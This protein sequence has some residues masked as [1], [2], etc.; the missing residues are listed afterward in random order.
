MDLI[1]K[2]TSA[3]HGS[4][5]PPGSKSHTIRALMLATLA[6]GTSTISDAL[7]SQD[8]EACIKT[9]EALGASIAV[10]KKTANSVQLAVVGAST[11]LRCRKNK[12]NTGNS[13]ITTRFLLPILG[14][15]DQSDTKPI[16]VN[17]GSQ[18][19]QRPIMPLVNALNELGMDIQVHSH[20][21]VW[22]LR[23]GGS[24]RGGRATIEGTTS[25]YISA[26]LIALPLAP[27]DSVIT[28]TDL[29]ERP[30]VEMTTKWLDN[31]KIAYTWKRGTAY[32]QF[33]IRGKQRYRPYSVSIPAD[34]SSA[35]YFLAAAALRNG[36]VSIKN[37][38]RKD[39]QGDK[40]LIPILRSM[41]TEIKIKKSEIIVRGG[42]KLRGRKINCNDI[43]DL[44]PTLAV[45]GT[46]A[47]GATTL[48]NVAHARL[49][50]TD[51]IAAMAKELSRMGADIRQTK[52]GLIITQS[53]LKG[54]T[55]WGHDDHRTIM[56]LAIA[57][58]CADGVTR[59]KGAQ[60]IA[61]TFP[62]FPE[63]LRSI[64]GNILVKK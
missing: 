27:H 33:S 19:R 60:G 15:R 36:S 5:I 20:K 61:K 46:Q 26:L 64:G 52:D 54:T 1:I 32:D 63:L 30:Y 18:M 21:S 17:C 24:L 11:P 41:G 28:V 49:K 31:H 53:A 43:P 34:F 50:E 37:L 8:T 56:A 35:S 42:K 6:K 58:L 38:D 10:R 39:A 23:V 14:L 47:R 57:G 29:N 2:Q 40:Q 59:V 45:L 44:V 12:I 4:I 16:T 7:T 22:P 48:Y 9:C 25:Q 3:L 55:V 62:Q 51:R 13:G